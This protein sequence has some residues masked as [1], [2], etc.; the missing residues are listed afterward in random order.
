A[1]G[2][3]VMNTRDELIDAFKDFREGKMGSLAE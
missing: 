3:F 1:H 2:P